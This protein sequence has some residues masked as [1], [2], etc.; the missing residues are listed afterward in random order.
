MNPRTQPMKILVTG[1]SG[2][3]GGRIAA[4]LAGSHEVWGVYR[5]TRPKQLEG[6]PGLTL[7]RDDL[8]APAN[9]PDTCDY[10]VHAA[11][12]TPGT[13]QDGAQHWRS[14]RDGMEHLLQWS[15]TAG[16]S[17]FM[18]FS[19]MDV[20]GAINQ[21]SIT[22]QTQPREPNTYGISKLAAEQLLK[23]H[24]QSHPGVRCI[25]IRLPGVVGREARRTF[26]PRMVEKLLTQSPAVVYQKQAQF[27]NIVYIGDL[28]RFVSTWPERSEPSA[29]AM[30]NAASSHPLPLETVIGLL[31][32]SLGHACE[33][34]ENLTG[35]PPFLIGTDL[36]RNF[37]FPVA[38][39]EASLRAYARE[40]SRPA[41]RNLSALES[42]AR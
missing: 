13:T 1:A 18:F 38:T 3:I 16:V 2:F 19:T 23:Q 14:N 7:I 10:V 21:A 17:R 12:D 41:Q 35:R 24:A 42:L 29:Y 31:A 39:T 20:Y 34:S 15:V 4:A 26:L 27:N 40:L 37:G 8:A 22:E 30:F 5:T 25:T 6:I 33:V 32:E 36:A 28:I 9:L 11:A